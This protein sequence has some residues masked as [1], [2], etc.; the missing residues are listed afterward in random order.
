MQSVCQAPGRAAYAELI[1]VTLKKIT[2]Y[3]SGRDHVGGQIQTT[4]FLLVTLVGCSLT[5]ETPVIIVSIFEIN[6]AKR[7]AKRKFKRLRLS[8][9]ILPCAFPRKE[10][11]SKCRTLIMQA[12]IIISLHACMHVISQT[13]YSGL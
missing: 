6:P 2:G 3:L 11:F 8:C 7:A 4:V 13:K 1:S 5:R 9:M 12:V 10:T